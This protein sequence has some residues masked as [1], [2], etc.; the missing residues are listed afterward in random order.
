VLLAFDGSP[1]A[2]RAIA[3]AAVLLGGAPVLV[4]HVW[5]PLDVAALSAG[6]RLP[7]VLPPSAE[8]QAEH[9][10][11]AERAAWELAADGAALAAERGLDA[12]PR[13][14]AAPQGASLAQALA[15]AALEL[16]A[17]VLVVAERRRP[18]PSRL[19]GRSPARELAGAAPCPVLVVPEPAGAGSDALLASPGARRAVA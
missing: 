5:W 11:A 10:G 4:V 12:R 2:H 8:L 13:A 17:S 3:E 6:A 1:G 15:P 7:G 16:D 18:W 19:L 9:D 14:I